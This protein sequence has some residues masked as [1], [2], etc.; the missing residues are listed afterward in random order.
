MTWRFLAVVRKQWLKQ[1]LVLLWL[2]TGVAEWPLMCPAPTR[3]HYVVCVA[4]TMEFARMTGP[5]EMVRQP[6]IQKSLGRAGR[7]LLYQAVHPSVR[8]N[9][10][11]HVP[12]PWRTSTN[13]GNIVAL[14]LTSQALLENVTSTLTLLLTWT[15]VHLMHV[16]L[17]ATRKQFVKL[18]HH[19]SLPVKAKESVSLV[20]EQINSVVS[21]NLSLIHF[22]FF[23]WAIISLEISNIFELV[24]VHYF[25]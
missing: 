25:T 12:H 22:F 15:T 7:S 5:W 9:R 21:W 16:S 18:W 4:T 19:T 6:Q 13:T 24:F 2:L 23:S 1:L 11:K 20:G 10:A 17:K 3:A 14:L 8:A